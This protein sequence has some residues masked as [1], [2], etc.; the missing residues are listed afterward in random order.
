[1]FGV[2]RLG[3]LINIYIGLWLVPHWIP[4]S[5]LGALLPLGQIGLLLG[6][7]L[8]VILVLHNPEENL[9]IHAAVKAQLSQGGPL[10]IPIT[11][12]LTRESRADLLKI[13]RADTIVVQPSEVLAD[14][15]KASYPI[16][17][18]R[19]D[20]VHLLLASVDPNR[21]YF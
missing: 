10:R 3:D 2:Q 1:M 12:K 15:R 21:T 17:R 16:A 6:L 19:L 4:A 9:T 14:L 7:P 8:A 11:G 20:G 13:A 5:Q 18:G